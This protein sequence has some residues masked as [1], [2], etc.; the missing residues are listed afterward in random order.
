VETGNEEDGRG[1]TESAMPWL[2]AMEAAEQ[3]L[4]LR[5]WGWCAGVLGFGGGKLAGTRGG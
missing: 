1:G 2:S 3:A 5:V 4:E